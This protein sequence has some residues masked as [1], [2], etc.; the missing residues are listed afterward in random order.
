MPQQSQPYLM[1]QFIKGL[2][3]E[4]TGLNYPEDAATSA[5][6]CIFNRIGNVTRRPGIDFEN[7]FAQVNISRT[8]ASI[9]TYKW[10]NVGGDGSTKILVVQIGNNLYFYKYSNATIT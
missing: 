1:N 10:N 8:N 4:F 5:S 2:K 7:H 3:T 6:N 9:S